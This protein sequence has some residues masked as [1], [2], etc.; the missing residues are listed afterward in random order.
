MPRPRCC[1]FI[2]RDPCV[3]LFKPCGVIMRDLPVVD[4]PVDGL[5]AMRLADLEG[6]TSEQ[7]AELMG[8]SRHTFGRMLAQARRAAAE[9]LVHGHALR[10]AQSANVR[11]KS[12]DISFP[13]EHKAMKIAVSSEGPGLE[14]MVDPRFGRAAGFVLVDSETM[15]NTYLDNGASQVLAQ[16]AGIETA[17]RVAEAGAEVVLSGYV[18][19]K[20]FEALKAA[21]IQI[22]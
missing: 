2:E 20:A 9:A 15:D 17:Q 21:D 6:M 16:G 10:I 19:P 4:L 12:H 3:R 5:E 13:K 1:R 8:V 7:G 11:S 18:G 14:S 22:C